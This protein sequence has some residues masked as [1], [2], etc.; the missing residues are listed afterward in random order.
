[1]PCDLGYF[2]C[3]N[4][5]KCLPQHLQC[6][7]VDDCENHV[8]EDNCGEQ[9]PGSQ[10]AGGRA[11]VRSWQDQEGGLGSGHS[12]TQGQEGQCQVAETLEI[13]MG[14]EK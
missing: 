12:R 5:T 4:T 6:N 1:M 14:K 10:R 13:E 9:A 2:P 11:G 7:G 3:G 8:D